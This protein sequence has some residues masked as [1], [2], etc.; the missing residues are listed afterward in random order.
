MKG[1]RIHKLSLFLAAGLAAGGL[2]ACSS[3][4]A[5]TSGGA[6][7]SGPELSTIT[8]D[9]RSTADSAPVWIAQQ[10]GFFKQEGLNVNIKYASGTSAEFAGLAAHTVD[11]ALADYVNIFGQ[12][13]KNPQL[14]VRIV[15]DDTQ[16]APETNA[17]MVPSSSKITSVAQLKGKKIAFS[18]PGTA[19]GELAL[20]ELLKGYGIGAHSY[21]IEAM[22]F[23]DMIEPLARGE[24]DA[25]FSV[26]P[27]MTLMESKIGAHQLV[28]LMS[29]P[30][31]DFP[32]LGWATT[33][34]FV[35]KY[36]RTV[37]AF[38]RAVDKGLQLAASNTP[39]VRQLLVKNIKT[40][41]P[42]IANVITLNTFNT[43]LSVAR[44]QRV[45]TVMEQF[46]ALPKS[47]NPNQLV[48]PVPSGS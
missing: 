28:D 37:A 47:F 30:M 5:A 45:A 38:Q 41:S 24:V 25:A 35:Q 7:G 14:G 12:T 1:P 34:Y 9:A 17:I 16:S 13:V 43:T 46:G 20:D 48:V 2:A 39:L 6:N 21:T 36:P 33:A 40:M 23:P 3:G 8:V 19:F 15:A 31:T 44:L 29:G 10:N 27:Y 42:K 18:S 32:V 26:Q 22:G 11:F 4:S